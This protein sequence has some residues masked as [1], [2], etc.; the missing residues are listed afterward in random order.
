MTILVKFTYPLA[1]IIVRLVNHHP[2]CVH[3]KTQKFH[4]YTTELNTNL[5][6]FSHNSK[7]VQKPSLKSVQYGTGPH[8]KIFY[9]EK[10]IL[11]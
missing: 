5:S 9:Q 7:T 3:H 6:F 1:T 4:L 8:A 11:K 2:E 10:E